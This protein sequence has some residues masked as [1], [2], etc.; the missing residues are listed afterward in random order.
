MQG[1][2]R[3]ANEY[4]QTI[5][6]SFYTR[7]SQKTRNLDV[8]VNCDKS[9]ISKIQEIKP[10][11]FDLGILQNAL[12]FMIPYG[13]DVD[14]QWFVDEVVGYNQEL[15]DA[16]KALGIED[17]SGSVS[18]TKSPALLEQLDFSSLPKPGIEKLHVETMPDWL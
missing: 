16:V 2:V 1:L 18:A 4:R 13:V 8:L 12:E 3:L 17:M 9:Q 15:A 5:S 11:E 6:G 7:Y 14:I 10:D